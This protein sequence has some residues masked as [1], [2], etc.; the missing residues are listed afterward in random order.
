MRIPAPDGRSHNGIPACN[1]VWRIFDNRMTR[2]LRYPKNDLS[3]WLDAS[4][5]LKEDVMKSTST[6]VWGLLAVLSLGITAPTLAKRDDDVSPAGQGMVRVIEKNDDKDDVRVFQQ[7]YAEQLRGYDRIDTESG[8]RLADLVQVVLD[9][10]DNHMMVSDQQGLRRGIFSNSRTKLVL[11][12]VNRG[13]TNGFSLQKRPT[14]TSLND[15]IRPGDLVVVAGYLRVGGGLVATSIRLLN[16]GYDDSQR[17]FDG[18]RQWGDVR[19]VDARR[20]R[21]TLNGPNGRVNVTLEARGTILV[22]DRQTTLNFLR[23]GDRVVAYTRRD[24]NDGEITAYRVVVIKLTDGYPQG[25]KPYRTDP[26]Y[27]DDGKNGKGLEGRLQSVQNGMLF[28]AMVLRAGD[29]EFTVRYSKGMEAYDRD[30]GRI[31][32]AKLHDGTRLHIDYIDINGNMFAERIE[33]Q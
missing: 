17:R 4:L 10:D 2:R 13:F 24:D 23:R 11:P 33:V 16:R 25:D 15:A 8:E 27:R 7:R 18:F 29:T 19:E 12:D 9:V 3:S 1:S 14:G 20:G 6:L 30:G 28:N 31:S 32:P 5:S 22:D 21:F 26:D